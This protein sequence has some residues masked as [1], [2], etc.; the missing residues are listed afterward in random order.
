MPVDEI[1]HNNLNNFARGMR[2]PGVSVAVAGFR[3]RYRELF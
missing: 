1:A 3:E 2:A